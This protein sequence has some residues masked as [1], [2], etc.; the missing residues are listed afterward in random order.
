[1]VSVERNRENDLVETLVGTSLNDTQMTVDGQS[2]REWRADGKP[3]NRGGDV[4]GSHGKGLHNLH[5]DLGNDH[6]IH[7]VLK[8]R[9]E[10]GIYMREDR[11][12]P[13][14]KIMKDRVRVNSTVTLPFRMDTVTI[15][16]VTVT[17]WMG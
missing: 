12:H 7:G 8:H 14:S 10:V 1:M 11:Q 4:L 9:G 17:G 16:S 5:A 3:M 2:R 15:T 13:Q 6:V